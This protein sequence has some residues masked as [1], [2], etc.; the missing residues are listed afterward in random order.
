MIHLFLEPLLDNELPAS[1]FG[2][3]AVTLQSND[4]W[5]QLMS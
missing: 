2:A 3:T 1:L 5:F 4:Q